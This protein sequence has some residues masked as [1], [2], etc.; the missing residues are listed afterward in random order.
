ML[1][2]SWSWCWGIW[3]CWLFCKMFHF[4]THFFTIQ[5]PKVF[6]RGGVFLTFGSTYQPHYAQS[7]TNFKTYLRSKSTIKYL[8]SIN[9]FLVRVFYTGIGPG[10]TITNRPYVSLW[11]KTWSIWNN[12]SWWK[13][14]LQTS[15]YLISSTF[16]I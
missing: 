10:A 12:L 5:L 8:T 14:K 4:F 9:A 6:S 15:T 7:T 16:G 2:D 13:S 3:L 11:M 1:H